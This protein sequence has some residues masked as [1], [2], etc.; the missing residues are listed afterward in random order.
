MKVKKLI[1]ITALL[2]SSIASIEGCEKK[3][4]CKDLCKHVYEEIPDCTYRDI[5][6]ESECVSTCKDEEWTQE[7]IDCVMKKNRCEDLN[8]CL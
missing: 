4:D 1:F 2:F 6:T 8:D 3:Y 7:Y 5:S